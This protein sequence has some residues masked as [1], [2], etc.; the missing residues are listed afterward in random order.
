M[1]Q[2]YSLYWIEE[3][4]EYL[5]LRGRWIS[6]L[7]S[8]QDFVHKA[9]MLVLSSRGQLLHGQKHEDNGFGLS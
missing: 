9:A 4:E 3:A 1:E 7:A 6:F 5:V 8:L 2:L